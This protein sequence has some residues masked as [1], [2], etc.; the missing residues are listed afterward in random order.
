MEK[1]LSSLR[2]SAVTQWAQNKSILC[3]LFTR[4][5]AL[6]LFHTFMYLMKTHVEKSVANIF[7]PQLK[8]FFPICYTNPSPLMRSWNW[9]TLFV[10]LLDQ[11]IQ[12]D[13]A[14]LF[15]NYICVHLCQLLKLLKPQ[16]P[17]PPKERHKKKQDKKITVRFEHF[18]QLCEVYHHW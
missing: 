14:Q 7:S 4:A 9:N 11:V 6:A 10:F 15:S 5:S 3:D 12:A 17:S 2:H 8:I 1:I 13:R 18:C 16:N